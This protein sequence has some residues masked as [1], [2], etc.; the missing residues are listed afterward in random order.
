[1]EDIMMLGM[2]MIFLPLR[3]GSSTSLPDY[4]ET[5]DDG[6]VCGGWCAVSWTARLSVDRTA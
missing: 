5:H 3:P 6:M 1:M 4:K 2:I